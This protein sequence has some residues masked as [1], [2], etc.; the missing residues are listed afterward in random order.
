[1][2]KDRQYNGQMI[3]DRQYNGELKKK[4]IICK[5]LSNSL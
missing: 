4:P 1:M 3:K 2:I 5:T